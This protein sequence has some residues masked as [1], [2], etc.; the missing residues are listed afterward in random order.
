[1][2]TEAIA[3]ATAVLA[4]VAAPFTAWLIARTARKDKR[5]N[6]ARELA[7]LKELNPD[8]H[9]YES[10][11]IRIERDI[12]GL[13]LS[14]DFKDSYTSP[15]AS[16]AATYAILALWGG[17]T[18][19]LEQ[20]WFPEPYRLPVQVLQ[21]ALV[22]VAVII[23]VRSIAGTQVRKWARQ[24]IGEYK[25][26]FAESLGQNRVAKRAFRILM[27]HRIETEK[28][29]VRGLY[30]KE[31]RR[32]HRN[33]ESVIIPAFESGLPLESPL[34]FY[35]KA[36]LPRAVTEYVESGIRDAYESVERKR[37]SR[38]EYEI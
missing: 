14:R 5:Q 3:A 17:F 10:L 23:T 26:R 11:E 16:L 20:P 30:Q 35:R 32:I 13:V 7:I 31:L 12:S 36:D 2:E 9:V 38:P 4:A 15:W 37:T 8:S 21:Y 29:N 25:N 33:I 34:E 18:Y 27:G 1:M 6:I 19:S 28:R 22:T 24:P